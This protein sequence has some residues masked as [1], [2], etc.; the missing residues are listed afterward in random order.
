M[1]TLCFTSDIFLLTF[2]GIVFIS[3]WYDFIISSQI[4][5]KIIHK[6]IHNTC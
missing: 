6:I 1:E 2:V 4:I 3:L 5:A